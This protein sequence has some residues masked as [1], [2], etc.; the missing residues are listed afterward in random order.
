VLKKIFKIS[1]FLIAILVLGI[2][3]LPKIGI[4]PLLSKEEIAQRKQEGERKQ[5]EYKK[6]IEE[7]KVYLLGYFEPKESK[8]F[9]SVPLKY[10]LYKKRIY[11]KKETY[12]AFLKMREAA[13][14]EKLDL[15]IVSATRN[16]IYQKDLWEKKWNGATLVDGKNLAKSIPNELERFQKILEYSATPGTSRHH[17]G[18]EIDINIA[19]PKYFDTKAGKKEY[20]WLSQNAPLFGF[21]QPY[22][23][24]GAARPNGYN[25]EK[26]HWSYKPI[27][28]QLTLDY[29]SI[30]KKEDIKGFLGDSYVPQFNLINDYVMSVNPDCL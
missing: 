23:E 29:K 10:V 3:L 26:W 8:D 7:E 1:I 20:A 18:T 17:W 27:S 21:C 28:R 19:D 25:E 30:I 11:L 13:L 9:I 5:A 16:F 15:K 12:E 4:A 24:K 2:F 6:K 22:I 14:K